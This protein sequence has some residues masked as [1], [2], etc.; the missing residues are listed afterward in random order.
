MRVAAFLL[1]APDQLLHEVLCHEAAHAAVYELHGRGPKPHG[2]E[3]RKLMVAAGFEPRVRL[4][5]A[6]LAGQPQRGAPARV[7]WEHRCPVCQVV[8]LA[9]RRV[10]EWRCAACQAA[11][12]AGELVVT[13]VAA[14][15]GA[16]R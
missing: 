2:L 15:R 1:G 9:G 3:W 10:P 7:L 11:G 13:R 4:K 12:L 6:L 16:D 8:R 14:S 5:V